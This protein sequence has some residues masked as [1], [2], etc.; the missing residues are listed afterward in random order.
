MQNSLFHLQVRIRCGWSNRCRKRRATSSILRTFAC[1]SYWVS[2]KTVNEI[3]P[4]VSWNKDWTGR[5]WPHL[6]LRMCAERMDLDQALAG[7]FCL[8]A[9]RIS[10]KAKILQTW[11]QFNNFGPV[12]R[13]IQTYNIADK[14]QNVYERCEKCFV[15]NYDY[16]EG[17]YSLYIWIFCF[18][19]FLILLTKRLDILYVFIIF[20]SFTFHGIKSVT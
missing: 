7:Y 17:L 8:P 9:W 4:I 1:D 5:T 3:P 2:V 13:W 10:R 11:W 12:L 18:A 14:S 6:H 15:K 16:V 19:C 20:Y